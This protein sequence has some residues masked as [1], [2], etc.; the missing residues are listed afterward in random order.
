MRDLDS[1]LAALVADSEAAHP[2]LGLE[3][4]RASTAQGR[5]LSFD[6]AGVRV[7]VEVM[8]PGRELTVVGRVTG[9]AP[10]DCFLQLADGAVREVSL[11]DLGWFLI[12]S[13]PPGRPRLRCRSVGGRR[14]T[15]AWVTL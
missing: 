7:D 2:D 3:Q 9:A 15:T 11:D 10:R 13:V 6:G 4:V 5:L 12:G 14:V 1:E 8:G